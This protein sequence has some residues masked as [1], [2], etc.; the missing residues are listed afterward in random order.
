MN[1]HLAV[2]GE[3]RSKPDN[4]GF[5]REDGAFVLFA[6]YA[7]TKPVSVTAAYV[8]L[9]DIATLRRQRGGYVSLQAGF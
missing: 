8:D 4:L 3:Y 1:S 5:A 6:A 2:G 7:L 9:G